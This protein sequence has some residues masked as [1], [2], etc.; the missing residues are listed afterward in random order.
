[1]KVIITV[2]TEADGAWSQAERVTV[3]NLGALPRFQALCDRY[4]MKPTYLCTY[5]VARADAFEPLVEWQRE[6]R[7]EVGAHLHP[8]TNPPFT[9][10]DAL[11]LDRSEYPGYPSELPI[12]RFRAKMRVLG[13]AITERTGQAPTSYRAG[14]WGFA[15]EHIPVLVELGYLVDCSVTPLVDR[16]P[17][18]GL[19]AGGPDFRRAPVA[20]YRLA[21]DDICAPGDSPLWEVPVTVVHPRALMRSS[22]LARR[23][24]TTLKRVR[25][26]GLLNRALALE[27]SW[28]RPYP[29]MNARKLGRVYEV[30]RQ[31]GL[32]VIEMMF[33]SSELLAGASESFPDARSIERV[34]AMLEATLKRLHADGCAGVTLSDYAR[35]LAAA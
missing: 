25:G 30:A 23:A 20:P 29:Q 32:P 2:D 7:C 12:E 26:A 27:P 11:D 17:Y 9:T 33:H 35:S 10:R 24:W 3:E 18:P 4:G 14:R 5:E 6:G 19:R 34:F 8:W 31:L 15:R 28:F 22:A 16:R 1:M 21:A 13:D